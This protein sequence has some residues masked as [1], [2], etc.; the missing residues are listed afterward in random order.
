MGKHVVS[1]KTHTQQQRNHYANQKNSNSK[2]Y[3][4][5]MNNHANQKNPN[6]KEG[7]VNLS[8]SDFQPDMWPGFR[9]D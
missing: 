3:R 8:K 7:K 4:T 6:N 9:N 1:A 5:R 2:D